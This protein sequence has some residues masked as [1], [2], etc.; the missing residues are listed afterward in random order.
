MTLKQ[1]AFVKTVVMMLGVLAFGAAGAFVS[2]LMTPKMFA[3]VMAVIIFG[4]LCYLV[5]TWNVTSLEMD[6]R[7]DSQRREQ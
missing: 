2:T 1:R 7:F 4:F 5:Y 3:T 6:E